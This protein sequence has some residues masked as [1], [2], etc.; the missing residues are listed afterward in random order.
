MSAKSTIESSPQADP[1]NNYII[2]FSILGAIAL[3]TRIH[4]GFNN[5]TVAIQITSR[6]GK[7]TANTSNFKNAIELNITNPITPKSLDRAKSI[8]SGKEEIKGELL[9][10]KFSVA[11]KNKQKIAPPT[12][13]KQKMAFLD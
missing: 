9:N 2:A 6:I 13:K 11:H 10:Y 8:L 3:C 4:V 12:Q 1:S 7:D 5:N